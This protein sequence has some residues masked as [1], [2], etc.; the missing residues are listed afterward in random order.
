MN[1]LPLEEYEWDAPH[2]C[3]LFA[4]TI[5]TVPRTVYSGVAFNEFESVHRGLR[6]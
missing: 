5:I 6:L 3:R 2:E 4:L 1:P